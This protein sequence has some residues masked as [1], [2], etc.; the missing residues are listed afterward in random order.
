MWESAEDSRRAKSWSWCRILSSWLPDNIEKL[1]IF[2]L[3]MTI[4]T[5]KTIFYVQLITEVLELSHPGPDSEEEWV[6]F[7]YLSY[8]NIFHNFSQTQWMK[9]QEERSSL[10]LDSLFSEY[11]TTQSMIEH[12]LLWSRVNWVENFWMHLILT[13]LLMFKI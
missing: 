4:L 9:T 5:E 11:F 6:K 3:N 1:I 2:Q 13:T 10:N 12:E 7:L 8:P